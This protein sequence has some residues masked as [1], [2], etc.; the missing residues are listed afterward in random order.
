MKKKTRKKTDRPPIEEETYGIE[1]L[2]WELDYSFSID[3]GQRV[4]GWPYWEHTS[5]KAHG[6]VIHP[7]KIKERNIDIIILGDRWKS[8]VLTKPEDYPGFEPK[9]VGSLTIRGKGSEYLGSVPY[10]GLNNILL[11]L[12]SRKINYLIL[13]GKPLYRGRADIRSTRFS[14]DFTEDD[15]S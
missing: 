13:T 10:D 7:E 8:L 6:K 3:V 5:L 4:T 1:I 14:K 2:E 15:W 9:A 11:L 12:Q